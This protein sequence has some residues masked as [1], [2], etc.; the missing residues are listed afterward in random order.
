MPE[1]KQPDIYRKKSIDRI[2]SPEKLDDYLKVTSPKVWM[3]LLSI[4]ILILGFI[5]WSILGTVDTGTEL[6]HPIEFLIH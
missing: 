4:I 5:I 1:N 3:I 2:N 6:I